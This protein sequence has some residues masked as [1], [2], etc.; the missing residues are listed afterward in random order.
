MEP[1]HLLAV[2]FSVAVAV[3]WLGKVEPEGSALQ[4]E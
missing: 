1:P 2:L 4:A 3:P